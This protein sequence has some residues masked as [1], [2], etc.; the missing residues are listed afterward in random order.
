MDGVGGACQAPAEGAGGAFARRGGAVVGGARWA[1]LADGGAA[2]W[3]RHP[4][5]GVRAAAG[6]GRR[7]RPPRDPGAERKGREGSP[8]AV[9]AAS[10]R[11]APG[12]GRPCRVAAP[13]RPAR[14]ARGGVSAACAVAQVS[15]RGAGTRVAVRISVTAALGGPAQR[16]QSPPPSR[17]G[18][19]AAGGQG[20]PRARRDPQA[21]DLPHAA[22]L[23]RHP[24]ARGG[25][26]HPDGAGAARPQGRG[27]HPALHARVGTRGGWRA[28]PA[29]PAARVRWAAASA[30]AAG[31]AWPARGSR[32]SPS[33]RSG[34]S[35]P[36][37]RPGRGRSPVA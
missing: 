14:G 23:L 9:A 22:A 27:D 31:S 29:R 32:G 12:A 7:F 28:Q 11:T 4:V 37:R 35:A 33:R 1:A 34:W 26:R 2:L 30:N 6:A 18:N 20:C 10:A 19:P 15:Q 24:P 8:C 25:A 13:G 36:R 3:R 5:D 21:G 16:G 17:R